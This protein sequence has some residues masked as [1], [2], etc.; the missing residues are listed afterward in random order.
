VSPVPGAGRQPF[1]AGQDLGGVDAEGGAGVHV[2]WSFRG[3]EGR[4]G[5]ESAAAISYL[6]EE[7]KLASYME[8]VRKG[9][10]QNGQLGRAIL[11]RPW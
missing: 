5:V 6:A 11:I 3:F 8:E 4:R 2:R 7:R 1:A 9:A 10:H